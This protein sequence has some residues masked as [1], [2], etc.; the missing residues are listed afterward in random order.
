[1]SH[2]AHFQNNLAITPLNRE[3]L[4]VCRET[5]AHLVSHAFCS[6]LEAAGVFHETASPLL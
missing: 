5:A 4:T 3:G 1:M 6:I 2:I